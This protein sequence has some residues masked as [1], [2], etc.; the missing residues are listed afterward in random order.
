MSQWNEI[1]QKGAR[2]Y[3]YYNIHEPHEAMPRLSR[4]FKQAGIKVVLDLGCGAGRNLLYLAKQ[5]FE[6]YG[7]DLAHDG[8]A[9]LSRQLDNQSLRA[10]LIVGDIYQPLPYPA[11]F[12]DAIVSVQVIQHG[13]ENQI[14][15]M[16][17][18][19]IRVLK[20]G[21]FIFVTVTGRISRRKVRKC[22]VRTARRVGERT[23]IPTLGEEKGLIHFIYNK[24][25]LLRHFKDFELLNLWKD[26]RD[27]YCFLGRLKGSFLGNPGIKSLVESVSS[28]DFILTAV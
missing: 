22:L 4:L 23:Y 27:Y 14:R 16:I 26:S 21:G 7:I 28:V 5:G 8:I 19:M 12:F 9:L 17:K 6:L 2:N 25:V 3:K 15:K 10:Q 1:Y 13:R 18:E 24:N 11:D 20:P